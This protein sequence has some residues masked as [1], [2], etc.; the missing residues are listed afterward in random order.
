MYPLIRNPTRVIK[1]SAITI[2][3]IITNESKDIIAGVITVDVADHLCPFVIVKQTEKG[4][5]HPSFR[6]TRSLKDENIERLRL[7]LMSINWQE[8]L[9]NKDTNKK[10]AAFR[11]IMKTL[12]DKNCPEKSRKF[13]NNVDAIKPW[14]TQGMLQSRVTK[15]NL[16]K[17]ITTKDLR[18]FQKYKEYKAIYENLIKQSHKDHSQSC[19]K[20]TVMTLEKCG[21]SQMTS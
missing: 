13:N 6:T 21:G 10:A 4:R 16:Y 5:D 8:E 14:I 17:W 9:K 2:D 15:N 1:K 11:S 12:L 20:R 7:Y 18:V 19:S 3:H